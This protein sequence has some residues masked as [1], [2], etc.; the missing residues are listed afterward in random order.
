M[1]RLIVTGPDN[2][3]HEYFVTSEMSLGRNPGNDITIAEEKASRRH[4][5][6]KPEAGK[7]VVEDLDSSNGTKVN[8]NKVQSCV[9]KHGDVITIGAHTIAFQDESAELMPI[10]R[11]GDDDKDGGREGRRGAVLAAVDAPPHSPPYQGGDTRGGA[12]KPAAEKATVRSG[13]SAR[14]PQIAPTP[15]EANRGAEARAAERAHGPLAPAMAIAG[16]VAAAIL[17]GVGVVVYQQRGT[18][19][20]VNPEPLPKPQVE[21]EPNPKPKDDVVRPVPKPDIKAVRPPPVPKDTKEPDTKTPPS[22]ADLAAAWTKALGERDRAIASGNFAGARA[23][24]GSFLAAHPGGEFGRKAQ[25]ELAD[26]KKLIE[27]ALEIMLKDAQQAAADKKYRVTT[28]RCTRI[29]AADPGGK[30]GGEA[31]DILTRIDDGTEPRFTDINARATAQIQAGQ[32]DK[33]AE[34]LDKALDELGGTKWAEQISAAQLQVLMARSFI[35]Q[36]ES[37]R[38]K[39]AAAGKNAPV[40]LPGKKLTGVLTGVTGLTLELKSGARSI[41]AP[42][43]DLTP[44]DLQSVLKPLNLAENHLELA[45][46]WLLLGKTAAAQAEVER[47]LLVPQQAGGA[48]RLVSLLPNQRNLH[49]YD[50]SKWQHQSDWDAISGSWSTQNDR[51]VLDSADGGDTVLRTA[52]LGGPFPA[53]NAH[54]SFDFELAKPNAGYFFAFEFGTEDKGAVSAIFTE[55]GLALHANLNGAVNEKDNWTPGPTHVDLAI[56]GDTAALTVNGRKIKPLEVS[57]LSALQGT[58]TFRVRESACSIDNVILR[59][60]E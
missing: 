16:T 41:Q 34:T 31:R 30:F 14:L 18:E 2:I 1:P 9:L 11:T 42:I 23:A 51:Y 60:V 13:P 43:K 12:P 22:D 38:A 39:A 8:G 36:L 27:A 46:L 3:P 49:V 6:F 19:V 33:A 59:N 29:A 32:L 17:V 52:A 45:Y 10:A 5:R 21:P 26:T 7:I 57:G 35:R 44:E 50:F 28:Q 56:S 58:I 4:C 48:I 25:Q 53:R 20:A 40:T 55:K 54:I 24:V 15:L 47:A 37:E